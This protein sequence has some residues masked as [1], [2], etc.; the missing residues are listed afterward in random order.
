M[1][2]FHH[3]EEVVMFKCLQKYFFWIFALFIFAQTPIYAQTTKRT[4]GPVEVGITYGAIGPLGDLRD[5][6][7]N[8]NLE[9]KG[10]VNFDLIADM[11]KSG[12]LRLRFDFSLGQYQKGPRSEYS[13]MFRSFG[14]G[15]EVGLSNGSVL[16]YVN[17]GYEWLSYFASGYPSETSKQQISLR[18]RGG[19]GWFIGGGSRIPVGSAKR[20]AIDIGVRYHH[21]GTASYLTKESFQTNPNETLSII[22]TRGP[23]HFMMFTLGFQYR[24]RSRR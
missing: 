1:G 24:P 12:W 22:P 16:P 7:G 9:K 6:V 13:Y 15:P 21:G 18:V 10:A 23:I 4:H 19:S 5:N 2:M 11:S 14:L 20:W 8:W 17:G 3:R